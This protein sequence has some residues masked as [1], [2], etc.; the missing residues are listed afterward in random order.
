MAMGTCQLYVEVNSHM[1]CMPLQ[2]F[3]ESG[4]M[5][6]SLPP[7]LTEPPEPKFWGLGDHLKVRARDLKALLA[8]VSFDLM[9]VRGVPN[10]SFL[11]APWEPRSRH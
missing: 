6:Q 5:L 11:G 1:A 8:R 7:R 2:L 10:C 9:A 3:T 4:S